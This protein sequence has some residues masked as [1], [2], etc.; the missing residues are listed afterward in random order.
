M[1]D[2]PSIKLKLRDTTRDRRILQQ[3][4]HWCMM[5]SCHDVCWSFREILKSEYGIF[6]GPQS[7]CGSQGLSG[8]RPAALRCDSIEKDVCPKNTNSVGEG[9]LFCVL[10]AWTASLIFQPHQHW[11]TS[12][13]QGGLQLTRTTHFSWLGSLALQKNTRNCLRSRMLPIRILGS[14][15]LI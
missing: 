3:R 12:Q 9:S 14:H 11:E 8:M 15:L 6:S 5:C 13:S 1:N 10:Q 2:L 4:R 7:W